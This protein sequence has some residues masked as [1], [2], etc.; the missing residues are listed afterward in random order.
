[1]RVHEINVKDSGGSWLVS[2]STLGKANGCT[3][4]WNGVDVTD[5]WKNVKRVQMVFENPEDAVTAIGRL[6][7]DGIT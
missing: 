5:E 4:C 7:R 6:L 3:V 2:A 1:M